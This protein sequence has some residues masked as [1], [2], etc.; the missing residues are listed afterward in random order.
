MN[1]YQLYNDQKF[2]ELISVFEFSG[3]NDNEKWVFCNSL[4]RLGKFSCAEQKLLYL[5]ERHPHTKAI[6]E[7]LVIAS[8]GTKNFSVLCRALSELSDVTGDRALST[9][10]KIIVSVDKSLGKRVAR[11]L[12]E[13]KS[14][15][16]WLVIVPLLSKFIGSAQVRALRRSELIKSEQE[17]LILSILLE[18]NKTT[19]FIRFLSRSLFVGRDQETY[20][21]KLI[22]LLA[23]TDPRSA[24]SFLLQ[25][26][27]THALRH[28]SF[29]EDVLNNLSIAF[30]KMGEFEVA[31]KII[32]L[33]VSTT[34]DYRKLNNAALV[35]S[36][37]K[38]PNLAEKV[39]LKII[40][41]HNAPFEALANLANMY[42]K[43]TLYEK[44]NKYFKLAIEKNPTNFLIKL[45]FASYLMDQGLISD[46]LVVL[47]DI[48]EDSA[49]PSHVIATAR[50]NMRFALNYYSGITSFDLLK[51][52]NE[53]SEKNR[54]TLITSV[55]SD[56]RLRV[57]L[58]SGD[59]KNHS[60][61]NFLDGFFELDKHFDIFVISNVKNKDQKTSIV[62]E[63]FSD[64]FIDIAGADTKTAGEAVRALGLHVIIDLAGATAGNRLDLL[65]SRVA[66]VQVSALGFNFSTGSGCV[67]YLITQD[68][69]YSAD[70]GR[71]VREN[72]LFMGT[73]LPI[74]ARE[75]VVNQTF[76]TNSIK[77]LVC[78]S[79][80][81]RI[82]NDLIRCWREISEAVDCVIEVNSADFRSEEAR[83]SFFNKYR[84]FEVE[85]FM[86][87][88][89]ESPIDNV[90]ARADLTLDCFPHNSGTTLYESL[91]CGV[92]F[93]S[94]YDRVSVGRF[95]GFLANAC[96]F[97]ELIAY[98]EVEYV[99]KVIKYLNSQHEHDRLKMARIARGALS[100]VQGWGDEL[101]NHI[102]SLVQHNDRAGGRQ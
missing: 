93:I 50:S 92:P 6:L 4:I 59:F 70:E 25:Y 5:S 10:A 1:I 27:K 79:R 34:S 82:N 61:F 101:A 71:Q 29:D 62:R 17:K 57:G 30:Q 54:A 22:Q 14:L 81:I 72:L 96:G 94:L 44:A 35:Y 89:Y 67:D 42:K 80:A 53:R 68:G 32:E 46:S 88:G 75:Y 38:K 65:E 55:R 74:T 56:A 31:E 12:D 52:Y 15:S 24:V 39:F 26:M 41:E 86:E 13:L 77:R 23:E 95:G 21:A 90:Y 87:L 19:A 16:G 85:K 98:S 76:Q 2:F 69:F 73:P 48:V 63:R 20:L 102:R 33:F 49:A 43:F 58:L 78:C 9:A 40:E 11:K 36:A 28:E 45:N 7:S 3:L 97:P 51:F 47:T 60:V 37:N 100:D 18:R 84:A 8:T 66:E 91:L 83:R 64:R 99:G